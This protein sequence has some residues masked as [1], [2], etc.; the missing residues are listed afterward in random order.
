VSDPTP[1]GDLPCRELVELVTD[2]IEGTLPAEARVRFEAHLRICEGC[3]VYLDQMRT[4]IRIA[5]RLRP[6]SLSPEA[7]ERLL[8]AFRGYRR[9][10]P[11]PANPETST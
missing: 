5:G 2:Y 11:A 9:D 6:S 1:A 4:T 7:R 10:A 3:E 8:R